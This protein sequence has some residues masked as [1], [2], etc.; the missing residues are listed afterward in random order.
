MQ[1]GT[2]R[3]LTETATGRLSVRQVFPPRRALARGRGAMLIV[4]V[5]LAAFAAIL[6]LVRRNRSQ[7]LDLRITRHIQRI[8][9]PRFNRL[10]QIVSWPGFPPQSRL[11]P[12]ALALVWLALGFPIEAAFQLL[13]WGVAGISAGIKFAV[14]R[15]RPAAADVR[16]AP[17][18]IGGTSFPSGHVL[19]YAGVYG[20]LAFLINTLV[21]PALPRRVANFMLISLIGLVGP[22]RVYLGHHWFTDVFASYLLGSSYLLALMAIY[23]RVKTRWVNQRLARL[24]SRSANPDQRIEERA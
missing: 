17:A 15:P 20:F 14:R 5:A 21:R 24:R 3:L 10:M 18:R 6:F 12:P 8:E 19:I 7:A 11:I 1:R 9:G 22:S 16:I 4:A 13:A 23:R 2:P